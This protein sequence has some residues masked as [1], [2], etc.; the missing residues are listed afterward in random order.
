MLPET[1]VKIN[2][3]FE[4]TSTL[5]HSTFFLKEPKGVVTDCRETRDQDSKMRYLRS[6][7]L[8]FRNMKSVP[9]YTQYRYLR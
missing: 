8:K 9:L 3:Y 2:I 4:S 5:L 7:R 6:I 1:F